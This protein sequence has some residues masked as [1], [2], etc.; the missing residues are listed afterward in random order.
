MSLGI[1]V[2]EDRVVRYLTDSYF[3][4]EDKSVGKKNQVVM[5]WLDPF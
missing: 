1:F 5:K 4:Q 2:K 3:P